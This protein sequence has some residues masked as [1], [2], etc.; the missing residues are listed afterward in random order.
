M[1]IQQQKNQTLNAS[2]IGPRGEKESDA[3]NL[4]E[5]KLTVPCHLCNFK[6]TKKSKLIE[7]LNIAHGS[8]VEI[9]PNVFDSKEGSYLVLLQFK[10]DCCFK[11]TV[12]I[13][14]FDFG[15]NM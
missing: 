5:T 1:C 12:T 8:N 15:T 3:L 9:E 14:A 6:T 7:H 2:Y 11:S 10:F 4:V 13:N